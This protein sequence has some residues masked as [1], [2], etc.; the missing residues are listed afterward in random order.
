M[1]DL[2]T[3][4]EINRLVTVFYTGVRKDPL[5][6]PVF[7]TKI[8]EDHWPAHMEHITDFWCSIFLK[9]GD[10]NGNPM[11]KHFDL[12]GITPQH[13]VRWLDLFKDTASKTLSPQQAKAIHEMAQR[14]AQSFQMGLAFNYDQ[15]G[16]ADNPFAEYGIR[17]SQGEA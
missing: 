13:F 12:A 4:T 9:T 8:S 10:F 16:R 11:R 2:F 5:L 1:T 7:A 17:R 3:R 6:A 14:I 15:S